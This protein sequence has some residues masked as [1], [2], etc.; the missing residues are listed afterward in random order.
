MKKRTY[1]LTDYNNTLAVNFGRVGYVVSSIDLGSIEANLSTYAGAG[2][3]G[4]TVTARSYGTR[5]VTIEG[6]IMADDAESMKTR[7][8]VLQKITVPTTDFWL[9]VDGKYRIQLSANSTIEYNKNWYR[10]N[11]YLTSFT[12]DAVAYSPFFQ[13]IEPVAAKVTGWIKDFHFPYTNESGKTF[14]FGHNSESKIIDLKNI[15]EVET[16]MTISF[17]ALGGTII[18]PY[19]QDVESNKKLQVNT[20]LATG[21][22]LVVNTAYGKKSVTNVT[23]GTNLLY[24][25]DLSSDW[26]QMPIG[27]SSFKYGFDDT[28]T[29]TLECNVSY[30]PLLIEV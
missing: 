4:Q 22:E 23:L 19:L 3:Y 27:T 13:T 5:D 15:S 11:E 7:K 25:F 16:G 12:I 24:S 2:Q 10:N 14:T 18:N 9:V 20:T 21:Q 26:L 1:T 6:H 30:T 28:S 29:G 17:K 8:A